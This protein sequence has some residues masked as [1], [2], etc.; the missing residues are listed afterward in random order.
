MP[1]ALERGLRRSLVESSGESS[2]RCGSFRRKPADSHDIINKLF[3]GAQC[4][5]D[6][7]YLV[8]GDLYDTKDSKGLSA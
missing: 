7:M 2:F 5:H 3:D 6:C 4:E 1:I 8:P